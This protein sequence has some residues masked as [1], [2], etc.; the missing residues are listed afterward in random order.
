MITET[1]TWLTDPINVTGPTGWLQLIGQHLMYTIITLAIAAAIALPIGLYVGHT[2]RL[3]SA[4]VLAT[5]LT[6]ALPTLG[7]LTLFALLAGIGLVAPVIALVVLAVP[8]ILAG[9]YSGLESVPRSTIDG[10]RAQGMTEMQIL[11]QV[12]VPLGIELIIGGLRSAFMQVLATAMLA[13]YV[14]NGGLGKLIFLGMKTEDYP[15]MLAGSLLVIAL[16]IL[17]DVIL[18]LVQ[19]AARPKGIARTA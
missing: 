6:R 13:A 12:E 11:T 18:A 3:R 15:V 2:G 16:A 17:C 19:R 10:A 7:L 8:S 9:A 5:G 1:L 14:G 4:A